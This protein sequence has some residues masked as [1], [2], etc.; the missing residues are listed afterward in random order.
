MQIF[1]QRNIGGYMLPAA[2]AM[3]SIMVIISSSLL[4]NSDY[5]IISQYSEQNRI[6]AE[7]LAR[8]GLEHITFL[9]RNIASESQNGDTLCPFLPRVGGEGGCDTDANT[10]QPSVASFASEPFDNWIELPTT[11][12]TPENFSDDESDANRCGISGSYTGEDSWP[13]DLIRNLATTFFIPGSDDPGGGNIARSQ[14]LLQ[15]INL[16]LLP[17]NQLDPANGGFTLESWVYL[18][19]DNYLANA[20]WPRVFDL[21]N[22]TPNN[23]NGNSN[24]LLAW[25][26]DTGNLVTHYFQPTGNGDCNCPNDNNNKAR[27]DGSNG[28][29]FP[30]RIWVHTSLTVEQNMMRMT[31]TCDDDSMARGVD[32]AWLAA[33]GPVTSG[34]AR[35]AL[36]TECNNGTTI[37]REFANPT[38]AEGKSIVTTASD[39]NG[40]TTWTG[41]PNNGVPYT[42]NFLG[43]SNW[44]Q[45]SF[46]QGYFHNARIWSRALT[47]DEMDDNIEND[48]NGIPL[49]ISTPGGNSAILDNEFLRQSTRISPRYDHGTHF[50]RYFT[51]MDNDNPNNIANS[52]FPFTFRV[53]SC[54]WSKNESTAQTSTFSSVLRY[55]VA[56]DER[57]VITNVK[58]Y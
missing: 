29:P 46:T 35:T 53:M 12:N 55:G 15:S 50:L 57:G 31:M 42:S 43:R 5:A 22:P 1:K 49:S 25:E 10:M 6:K 58:R 13:A 27:I 24:I 32:D 19:D 36:P 7:S 38:D 44:E 40:W 30:A 26:N 20:H 45:D 41:G 16:G 11:I 18:T 37:T 47:E 56:D 34:S 33:D 14:A 28:I 23:N 8:T 9:L 3:V 4:N 52:S 48:L 54:A 39:A 17:D 51:V 21:G 2:M